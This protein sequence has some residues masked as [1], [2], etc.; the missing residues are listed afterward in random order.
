VDCCGTTTPSLKKYFEEGDV[1]E[2]QPTELLSS[3]LDVGLSHVMV[4]HDTSLY[5]DLEITSFR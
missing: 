1:Y 3:W 4:D 5:D 2:P